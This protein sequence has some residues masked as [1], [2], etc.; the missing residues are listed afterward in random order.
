ML[1]CHG[2]RCTNRIRPDPLADPAGSGSMP[3]PGKLDPAGSGSMPDPET[4]DPAGSGSMPDPENPPDIRPDP[5]LDPVHLYFRLHITQIPTIV[6][7]LHW[8]HNVDL[9]ASQ[10]QEHHSYSIDFQT[11]PQHLPAFLLLAHFQCFYKNVGHKF[12]VNDIIRPIFII[13]SSKTVNV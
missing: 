1:W 8:S 5:D 13:I 9:T 10:S 6:V 7:T 12:T 4:L 3:D 2:C 11:P